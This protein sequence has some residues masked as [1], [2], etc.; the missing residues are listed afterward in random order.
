MDGVIE[1]LYYSGSEPNSRVGTSFMSE[2][3]SYVKFRLEGAADPDALPAERE[4]LRK[5]YLE[6]LARD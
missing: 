1:A 5:R 2:Q 4:K 6:P 3:F